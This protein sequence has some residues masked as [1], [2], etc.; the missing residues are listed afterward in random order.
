MA[1]A[2]GIVYPLLIVVAIVAV[3]AVLAWRRPVLMK[4]ATRNA[5]RRKTQSLVVVLGLMVGTA[6]IAGSLVTGDT[7]EFGIK[8]GAYKALGPTDELVNIEGYLYFPEDVYTSLNGNAT[9]RGATAGLAPMILESAAIRNPRLKQSEPRVSILGFDGDAERAFAPFVLK[10]GSQ[11]NAAALGARDV[12][13]S[14]RVAESLGAVRGDSV[15]LSYSITPTPIIPRF[16]NESGFLVAAAQA[17]VSLPVP[18]PGG[19]TIDV[20]L[21]GAVELL[22]DVVGF[23][24]DADGYVHHPD[25]DYSRTFDVGRGAVRITTLVFPGASTPADLDVEIVGPSGES[26]LSTDGSVL[27]PDVP[28]WLNVTRGADS[29]YLEKGEWTLNVHAKAASN[30]NWRAIILVFHEVYDLNEFRNFTTA[31]AES[32]FK[33]DDFG[34]DTGIGGG[35][36]GAANILKRNFTV[37]GV[38]ADEAAGSLF[39]SPTVWMRLTSAQSLFDKS[40]KIN[41]IRVTNTGDTYDGLSESTRVTRLLSDALAGIRAENPDELSL[42]RVQAVASK[43]RWIS[44]AERA[45]ELFTTF[46]TTVS[47]FTIMAGVMLIVNIFVMLAEERKSELGMARAVG[48]T[49]RDL[50]LLFAFEGVLYAIISAVI[51]IF[52]GLLLAW[53]LILGFNDILASNGRNNFL[54][55]R[56]YFEWASLA[57]AFAAG[58]VITM[59]TVGVTSWR[60]SRLNIVR[61][62]RRLDEPELPAGRAMLISSGLLAAV[63]VS[64]TILAFA[65]DSLPLKIMGPVLATLGFAVILTRWLKG[66]HVYP[67]AGG[68]IGVYSA[69]T[70]FIFDTPDELVDQLMGPV[71][72]M[73]LVIASALI[74]V[75]VPWVMRAARAL[76]LKLKTLRAAARPGIAYPLQK[77]MRTGLTIAMFALVMLVIAAFTTFS[78]TFAVDL[79]EQS[80][81]YDVDGETTVPIGDLRAWY[82]ENGPR[83]G[84]DPFREVARHD[85]LI[86]ATAFGGEFISVNGEKIH[87]QG[88][89]RDSVYAFDRGFA[90]NNGYELEERDARFATDREAYEA[91][92]DDSTLAIVSRVYTFKEDGSPGAFHVG[93]SL[94]MNTT[95]GKANF[96]VIGIQKQI[97]LGGVWVD[98]DVVRTN[99]NRVRGQY[100]FKIVDGADPKLVAQDLEAAFEDAGMN[101]VSI[102]EEAARIVEQNRQFMTLFQLF[103]GFGLVVGIASLGI[104]TARA[105]LERRQEI[106]ML[107]A[108]GFQRRTVLKMFLVEIFFTTSLGIII[109]T[110]LGIFIAYS[111]AT[112]ALAQF[113]MSFVVPVWDL[114]GVILLTYVAVF[115]CTFYPAWRASRIPPAEAVRYIE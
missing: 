83:D 71:R 104:I 22:G 49:R 30:T 110:I 13:L 109:G 70:L 101:A 57:I 68:G 76:L 115:V 88:P 21:R 87:Y 78:A 89:P 26:H 94:A 23:D 91:I 28:A 45:G 98:E 47:S 7:L 79:K 35:G 96:T 54:D 40:G 67:I 44:N 81:G 69:L 107:R 42:E 59:V 56:F 32:G 85:D 11:F 63:G 1:V 93:A 33:P 17:P 55:L 66:R 29:A 97:Y 16:S 75:H 84:T 8:G 38:L 100:L 3:F 113:G 82:A 103:L 14:A 5:V 106:G 61:A 53:L 4:M 52:L 112:K 72:G 77:K 95:G 27:A 46:L 2:G 18:G 92:L 36:G 90:E 48:L 73:I 19:G 60:T 15:S 80:G 114:I 65:L 62:I 102:D 99:F 9:I 34:I 50:N 74:I 31:L 86:Y 108:I 24:A 111:V 39:L 51:G 64:A 12:L 37:A 10:D 43:E 58:F 6:I 25:D 20:P 105:V 41:L